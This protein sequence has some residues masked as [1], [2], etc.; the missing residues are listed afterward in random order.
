MGGQETGVEKREFLDEIR[1]A[2][3]EAGEEWLTLPQ[4][5]KAM[6]HGESPRTNTLRQLLAVLVKT[7]EA[8][9][10]DQPIGR[11][12]R[13]KHEESAKYST[14]EVWTLVFRAVRVGQRAVTPLSTPALLYPDPVHLAAMLLG[15]NLTSE[16]TDNPWAGNDKYRV[17]AWAAMKQGHFSFVKGTLEWL[18]HHARERRGLRRP[19]PKDRS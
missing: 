13:W 9:C 11:A 18:H 12:W 1:K 10:N 8:E 4:L 7:G 15:R 5:R 14:R 19:L 3:R 6:F 16:Q 17:L 2:L